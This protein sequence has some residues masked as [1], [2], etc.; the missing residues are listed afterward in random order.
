MHVLERGVYRGPHLYSL[1]PMIR[2]MLDLGPLE[3]RPSN[4]IEG[5]VDGL[6]S[7]LPGVGR[8]H[9]SLG[10]TGGFERR[11]RDGT[12]LGHVT[13]HVA[14]ELQTLAG[15][16]TTHKGK[17]RGVPG[18]PGVYNLMFEYRDEHVGLCAGRLALQLVDSLLPPDVRGVRGLDVIVKDDALPAKFDLEAGLESLR[19]L[20]RRTSLG[21][22]T[23]SF[24]EEARRRG[25]PWMRLDEYSLVQ[26]G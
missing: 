6:L 1:R 24:V 11:L 14:L 17:T 22:T 5:F 3:E 7:V 20:V 4:T 12:W 10:V 16:T 26:I 8:H 2:I 19:R 13:E 25:L 18:R 21:P 15:E 23:M 9:C